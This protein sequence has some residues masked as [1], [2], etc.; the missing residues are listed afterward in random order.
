MLREHFALEGLEVPL[1][2]TKERDMALSQNYGQ[3]DSRSARLQESKCLVAQQDISGG[4]IIPS[5]DLDKNKGV[6][7]SVELGTT[8]G[9]SS[10]SKSNSH[11]SS[12]SSTT[13]NSTRPEEEEKD[14]EAALATSDE[15]AASPLKSKKSSPRPANANEA[16]VAEAAEAEV[17]FA[18]AIAAFVASAAFHSAFSLCIKLSS[19]SFSVPQI[20]WSRYITQWLCVSSILLYRRESPIGPP[21]AQA[22]LFSRGLAGVLS[23]TCHT[24]AVTRLPLGDAVSIH[25][26]YPVITALLAPIFLGEQWRVSAVVAAVVATTGCV[27]IAQGKNSGESFKHGYIHPSMG[28]AA[29]LL[30]A[31]FGSVTYML[32]RRLRSGGSNISVKSEVVVWWYSAV[33]LVVLSVALPETLPKFT[34]EADTS[35]WEALIAVGGV[36]IAEQLLVTLGFAGVSAGLGTL[37]MTLETGFAF[38]FGWLVLH[39]EMHFMTVL[40]AILIVLAVGS[41]VST[42]C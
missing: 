19:K 24:F 36:S 34:W 26:M 35:T 42:K 2:G 16:A 37:L 41:L 20:M 4:G 32:I 5:V 25:A 14:C 3:V 13:S 18:L 21:G 9:D 28:L 33:S 23:Q 40:G 38:L 27:L 31:F 10:T 7:F 30:G 11:C 39:D 6:F 22:F 17:S 15:D 8:D 29:A 1:S 12:S